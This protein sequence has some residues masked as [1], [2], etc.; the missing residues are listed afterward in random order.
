MVAALESKSGSSSS[1]G[2]NVVSSSQRGEHRRTTT[3]TTSGGIISGLAEEGVRFD[4]VTVY[5]PD[6]RLLVKD[7]TFSLEPGQNLFVTGANGA[8]KTS[9]FRV[10]AGLWWVWGLARRHSRHGAA[11]THI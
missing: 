7:V 5:S 3:P 1:A 11:V 4:G 2:G 8:G 6:G 10:L 9:L